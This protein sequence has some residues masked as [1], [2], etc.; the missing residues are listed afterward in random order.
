MAAIQNTG[1]QKRTAIA[2]AAMT[3]LLTE[4]KGDWPLRVFEESCTQSFGLGIG[5]KAVH[6][7]GGNQPGRPAARAFSTA[8][9]RTLL[10]QV[11]PLTVSTA[12]V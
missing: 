12:V 1:T 4:T 11:A 5:G 3:V 8:L 7:T 10:E 2:G 9:R 6:V